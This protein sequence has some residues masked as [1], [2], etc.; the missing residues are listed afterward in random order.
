MKKTEVL[1]ALAMSFLSSASF[2]TQLNFFSGALAPFT[3]A[4]AGH[5]TGTMLVFDAVNT[6]LAVWHGAN[7]SASLSDNSATIGIGGTAQ[8]RFSSEGAGAKVLVPFTLSWGAAPYLFSSVSSADPLL[9]GFNQAGAFLGIFNTQTYID[10]GYISLDNL[11]PASGMIFNDMLKAGEAFFVLGTAYEAKSPG[12]TSPQLYD[13]R[14]S[15][16]FALNP[17]AVP[18]PAST[19]LLVISGATMLAILRRRSSHHPKKP[20]AAWVSKIRTKFP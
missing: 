15:A 12:T 11:L 13:A 17:S 19:W 5:F 8:A 6:S 2:A 18:E 7:A 10:T 20:C 4:G 16:T 1:F 3:F 9:S 14:F